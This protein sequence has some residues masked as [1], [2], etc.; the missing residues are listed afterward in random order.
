MS[1]ESAPDSPWKGTDEVEWI[2]IQFECGCETL[3]RANFY[4]YFV[5][6]CRH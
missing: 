2:R 3:I 5:I 4:D 1:K 6:G